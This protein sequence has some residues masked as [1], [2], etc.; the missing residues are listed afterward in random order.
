MIEIER[1]MAGAAARK[2]RTEPRDPVDAGLRL[3]KWVATPRWLILL[4]TAMVCLL[5]GLTVSYLAHIPIAHTLIVTF[6]L[7][8]FLG[9][10]PHRRTR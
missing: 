8:W 3:Q 6:A 5:I 4:A 7:V 9:L 2:G 10:F 1:A